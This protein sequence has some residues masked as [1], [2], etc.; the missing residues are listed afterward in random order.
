MRTHLNIVDG[1]GVT[2][3]LALFG[4]KSNSSVDVVMRTQQSSDPMALDKSCQPLG[5][6]IASDQGALWQE[7][8]SHPKKTKYDTNHD[9]TASA[10]I[11][12]EAIWFDFGQR[13]IRS[14]HAATFA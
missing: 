5:H 11:T 1:N 10:G 8:K 7:L 2:K 4:S 13:L 14:S 3:K 9:F 6:V 12:G